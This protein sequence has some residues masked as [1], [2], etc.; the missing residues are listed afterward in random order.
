MLALKSQV[1]Y[2]S[3]LVVRKECGESEAIHLGLV[4]VRSL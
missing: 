1:S 3:R 4:N 2:R